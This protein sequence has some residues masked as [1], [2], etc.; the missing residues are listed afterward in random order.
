M[1]GT[2]EP[3]NVILLTIEQH[4]DA[5]KK[6]WEQHGHWQDKLAWM[7]LSGQIGKEEI[8]Q[9]IN[10]QNGKSAFLG[11]KHSEESKEKM[12]RKRRKAN[13]NDAALRQRRH[14]EFLKTGIRVP[15]EPKPVSQETREKMRIA[16]LGR[17]HSPEAIQ[18]M[19]DAVRLSHASGTRKPMGPRK[20]RYDPDSN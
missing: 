8:I 3:S 6:L 15:V 1:G 17:K 9:S 5:H 2:Y 18:R 10:I 13:P 11:K 4:A 16:H 20:L 19:R 7:G 14:R 12:S